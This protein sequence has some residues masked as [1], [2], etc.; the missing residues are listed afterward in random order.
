MKNLRIYGTM[1]KKQQRTG[2]GN[3]WYSYIW[4]LMIFGFLSI[5]KLVDY[6][7][8]HLPKYTHIQE[9]GIM[10]LGIIMAVLS[11]ITSWISSGFISWCYKNAALKRFCNEE[12]QYIYQPKVDIG[13]VSSGFIGFFVGIFILPLVIALNIEQNNSVISDTLLVYCVFTII[14]LV[15]NFNMQYT[16]VLLTSKHASLIR[17]FFANEDILIEDIKEASI[18]NSGILIACKDK[19]N[20][21]FPSRPQDKAEKFCKILQ[22]LIGITK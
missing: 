4:G 11:I 3:W 22:N 6:G 5:P 10:F 14:A 15:G 21:V 13:V 12:V 1:D 17:P 18:N 19:Y 9:D 7:N 8:N 16:T 2:V 20:T